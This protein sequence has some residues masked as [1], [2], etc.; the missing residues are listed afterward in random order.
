MLPPV[1]EGTVRTKVQ[2]LDAE[3]PLRYN[4]TL[5]E[6]I[7]HYLPSRAKV[8]QSQASCHI[9]NKEVSWCMSSLTSTCMYVCA[10]DARTIL[11]YT[12]E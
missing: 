5:F 2:G 1:I 3:M 7:D 11:L 4:G 8:L 10:L 9:V 12:L 6:N